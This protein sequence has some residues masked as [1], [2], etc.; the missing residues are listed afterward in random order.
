MPE[1]VKELS[2]LWQKQTD[3]FTAAVKKPPVKGTGKEDT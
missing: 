1:K 2:E 3:A